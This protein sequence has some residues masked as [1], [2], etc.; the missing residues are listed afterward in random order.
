MALNKE[1]RK[2]YLICYDICESKKRTKLAKKLKDFGVRVQKSVFEAFLT[3]D[4]YK[5]MVELVSPFATEN[6][7]IR[8]YPL[9][10]SSYNSK[11]IVGN[12]Y[13]YLPLKDII[14]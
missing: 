6:D 14:I 3:E 5:E 13:N 7:S 8:I 2:Y 1:P 10:N 11:T 4:K 9:T 12:Q